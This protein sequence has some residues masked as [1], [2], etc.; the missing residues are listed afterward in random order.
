MMSHVKEYLRFTPFEVSVHAGC[1]FTIFGV[2]M[3]QYEFIGHTIC[4]ERLLRRRHN[5]ATV[6]RKNR[7]ALP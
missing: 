4:R 3:P 2:P 1:T 5:R 6:M 7:K